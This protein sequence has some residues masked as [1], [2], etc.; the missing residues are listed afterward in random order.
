MGSSAVPAE[1]S[2][3]KTDTHKNHLTVPLLTH[4]CHF[5]WQGKDTNP[6]FLS[7]VLVLFVQNQS[8]V[9]FLLLA[10][11]VLHPVAHMHTIVRVNSEETF[12]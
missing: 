3:H 12:I 4:A 1:T 10:W 2:N 8:F 6:G 5:L 9:H 11:L 7:V